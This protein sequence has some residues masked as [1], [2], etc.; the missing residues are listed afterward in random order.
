MI[1]NPP[2]GYDVIGDIHGYGDELLMLLDQLG[3]VHDGNRFISSTGRQALFV[4]D[5]V[6]GGPQQRLV[7]DTVMAMTEYGSAQAIMGNHEFN[8]IAFHTPKSP[9]SNDW[10]RPR[11]NKNIAQHQAFL[12]EYAATPDELSFVID[13]FKQLPLW[14]DVKGGP[15]LVH[16]CWHEK[17]MSTINA[18]LVAGDRITD[19]FMI[20]ATTEGTPIF[21][22]IETLLK[23]FEIPIEEG[24]I[25]MHGHLRHHAR[26]RWWLNGQQRLHDVGLPP[27]IVQAL[28][29]VDLE[30]G[31]LPGYGSDQKPLFVGHYWWRGE[32]E[33]VTNNVACVDYAVADEG[34]L[35]AYR[36]N[37]EHD[38]TSEGFVAVTAR[39]RK[40]HDTVNSYKVSL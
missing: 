2:T 34:K 38:L 31:L 15:R 26:T 24:F 4:G 27:K 5:F 16:A 20:N 13:W 14:L 21:E 40:H 8:A 33:P 19:E 12:D 1:K 17:H 37:G 29:D 35:V 18:E 6:D 9:G 3:Y 7:L 10:L 28:P 39:P 25:D 30:N 32:L 36:W 22:A 11:T 23:G